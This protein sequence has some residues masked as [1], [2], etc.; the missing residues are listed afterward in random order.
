MCHYLDAARDAA[1]RDRNGK[2]S[3]IHTRSFL[4]LI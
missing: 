2:Q 3:S 4:C 1:Q